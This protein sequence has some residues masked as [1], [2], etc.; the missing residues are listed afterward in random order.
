M[1]VCIEIIALPFISLYAVYRRKRV[2]NIIGL[3]PEPLINN[4]YHKMALEKYGYRAETFVI[5]SYFITKKFDIDISRDFTIQTLYGRVM[6][7]LQL[8]RLAFKYKVLY[9]YFHGGPLGVTTKVLWRF[10]PFFYKIAGI[11][12][13]VMPYGGDIQELT[14]TDNLYFKHTMSQDYPQHRTK[15]LLISQK[16]DLWTQYADHV[17]GGCDWVEYMYY[18]DTLML[19]HFSIDTSL[20]QKVKNTQIKDNKTFRIFHAPNHKSIKG[21]QHLEDAVA[22]LNKEGYAI[23]LVMLTEVSNEE[24][25]QAISTVDIVADQFVIGWYAMFALEAMTLAKPVMCFLR[26]DFIRLYTD[27]GLLGKDEIPI[28]NTSVSQISD[29]L[30]WAYENREELDRIGQN[31]KHYVEKHHSI[32]AVGKI[33]DTINSQIAGDFLK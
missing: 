10:E 24:I 16:I 31:S 26:E 22:Q 28:I 25:L 9:F 33:F 17:I 1:Q 3:G 20:V 21:T 32:E 29:N 11:K 14:R 19:A 30:R 5:S 23:E 12:T 4:V 15:R 7:F 8:I 13:V 27:A 18:W 2:E 6:V